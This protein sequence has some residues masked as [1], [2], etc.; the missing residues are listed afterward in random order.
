MRQWSSF[1]AHSNCPQ[2]DEWEAAFEG[3]ERGPVLISHFI[4]VCLPFNDKEI[5]LA[6]NQIVPVLAD[7]ES[8]VR[9][10]MELLTEGIEPISDSSPLRSYRRRPHHLFKWCSGN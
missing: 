4:V 5:Q 10:G 1:S 3:V 2:A 7:Q 8:Y 9:L 6:H